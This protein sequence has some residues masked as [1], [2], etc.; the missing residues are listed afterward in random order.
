MIDLDLEY[1]GLKLHR[2]GFREWFLVFF[3]KV[4]NK[5]FTVEPIHEELFQCFQDIYDGKSPRQ[6]INIPPRSAK[7]TMS[8]YFIA[9]ALAGNMMSNFIYTS[10]SQ[11]LLSTN[12]KRLSVILADKLYEKMYINSFQE[13]EIEDSVI[14]EFWKSYYNLNP[15]NN[16]KFTSKCITTNQGGVILFNSIGS[17][18]TGFGA[19]IVNAK[20]FS[21]ALIIDDANKPGE[22]HSE[23]IR[24]KVKKYFE[25]TLLSR[26]NSSTIP[27]INI[28]QRLHVDDLSGFLEKEYNFLV[29]KKPLLEN[30]I[31]QIPNQY[32]QKR[33]EELQKNNYL[34]T[35]QYQQEPVK[36]GGNL[37]KTEWFKNYRIPQERYRQMYMVAD[38]AFSTKTSA[39]NSAF[40]LIGITQENDLHILDLFV[41][42]MD[43]V[44]LKNALISFYQKAISKYSRFNTISAIY[45]ENKGSGQALIPELKQSRLPIAELYPTYYNPHLKKEQVTD[46]YTRYLEISTDIQAGYV[47]IPENSE[48]LL[49]FLREC[50]VFDGLGTTHDDMVDCLIYALKIRRTTQEIDWDK[51]YKTMQTMLYQ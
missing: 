6:I 40:M 8:I 27:I 51:S 4:E 43:F 14:D 16:F 48:W 47:Y 23:R 36:L 34:F 38:T 28:Q 2:R 21:G 20:G 15:N 35:S 29:L 31:C 18:I 10:F 39:D 12:S 7:T 49:D 42:K 11:E 1:V 17:A 44:E 5:S 41:K 32:S 45:I 30:G 13:Q 3:K 22:I 19:G 24:E 37:I 9:Y 33:I 26:L 50:E 46:K 25:E